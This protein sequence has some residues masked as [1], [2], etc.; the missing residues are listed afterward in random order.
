VVVQAV[1]RGSSRGCQDGKCQPCDVYLIADKKSGIRGEL[2]RWFPGCQLRTWK[3]LLRRLKGRVAKAVTL[4][5]DRLGVDPASPIMFA[6]V[7]EHLGETDLSNFNRTIRKHEDF[8]SAIDDLGLHEVK[9]G[10]G[11]GK[12]AFQRLFSPAEGYH[13]TVA[14]L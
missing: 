13:F 5:K 11:R 1:G 12:N 6:D 2:K 4:L 7:M 10:K 14:D 8:R 3:P 9:I